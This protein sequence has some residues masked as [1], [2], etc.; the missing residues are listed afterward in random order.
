MANEAN[1]IS[2]AAR[3]AAQTRFLVPRLLVDD[4]YLCAELLNARAKAQFQPRG[5]DVEHLDSRFRQGEVV[6][7]LGFRRQRDA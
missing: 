1:E 3:R 6:G 4:L 5:S 7:F 2:S